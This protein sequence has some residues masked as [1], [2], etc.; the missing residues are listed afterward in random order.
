[1]AST[2]PYIV[3]ML[4][5]QNARKGYCAG[6]PHLHRPSIIK[7][8]TSTSIRKTAQRSLGRGGV[9]ACVCLCVR[10]RRCFCARTWTSAE[11]LPFV[12]TFSTF[13]T[14]PSP[15]SQP[16]VVSTDCCDII[17]AYKPHKTAALSGVSDISLQAN[18]T[19]GSR[20]ASLG[21]IKKTQMLHGVVR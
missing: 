2:L 17:A 6:K 7:T 4:S 19:V 21:T 14:V 1:M 3:S 12:L 9:C 20:T 16:F 10:V 18:D 8:N 13:P 11:I 5:V 15:V